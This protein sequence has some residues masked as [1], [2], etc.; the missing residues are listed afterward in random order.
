MGTNQ[1]TAGRKPHVQLNVRITP[2][3]SAALDAYCK[4]HS[5]D[6]KPMLVQLLVMQALASYIGLPTDEAAHE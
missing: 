1:V 2:E 4:A 3:M 5:T 6:G